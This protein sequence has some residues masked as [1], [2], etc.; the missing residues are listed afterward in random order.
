MPIWGLSLLSG[1]AFIAVLAAVSLAVHRVIAARRAPA[2]AQA[3][4]MMV[5]LV[6]SGA[7]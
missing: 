4:Q 5:P 1:V 2:S 3:T 7:V 6:E